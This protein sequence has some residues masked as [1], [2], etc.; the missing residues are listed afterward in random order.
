ME[1]NL[2]FELIDSCINWAKATNEQECFL[3]IE[4]LKLE[5]EVFIGEFIKSILKINNIV[6][7][8][9]K[10]CEFISNFELMQKIKKIP[11]LTL[12]YIATNQ[13]LYI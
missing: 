5:K 4:K 8:F 6:N 2:H 11:E 9:E 13:S 7:E 1:Y 3:V 12:K 10:L